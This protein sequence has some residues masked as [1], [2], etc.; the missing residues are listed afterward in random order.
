MYNVSL[1]SI[2]R[3]ARKCW[4]YMDAYHS[5]LSLEQVEWAMKKQR[6]HRRINMSLI[7][8]V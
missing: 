2:R 7:N 8:K 5:G 1:T 6:S 4:R 3:Y